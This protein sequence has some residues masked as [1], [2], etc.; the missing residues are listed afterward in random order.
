MLRLFPILGIFALTF[1]QIFEV[2]LVVDF[3][4]NRQEI[5]DLY[6]ENKT[7][8]EL[9]CEGSCHLEKQIVAV[10]GD[11]ERPASL[12]L[13]KLSEYIPTDLLEVNTLVPSTELAI[14]KSHYLDLN[15]EFDEFPQTPPPQC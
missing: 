12:L 13:M 10:E 1:P 3:L 9:Q 2:C 4:A 14:N 7:Q 6:C 15:S 5:T 11:K 8:P